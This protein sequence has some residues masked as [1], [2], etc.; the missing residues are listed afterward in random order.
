MRQGSHRK[1][2]GTMT[3]R[4]R[5][6]CGWRP[7]ERGFTL[8]E[9]LIVILIVGILA[10]VAVPLYLGYTKDAKIAEGKA[11]A[12]SAMTA[13]QGC[14]QYKGAGGTC[15]RADLLGDDRG[16]GV[17]GGG[18]EP[19]QHRDV[20]DEHGRDPALLDDL[21]DDGHRHRRRRGLLEDHRPTP[22]GD[23]C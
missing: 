18:H 3:P 12:G 8:V 17:V 11:L 19:D 23:T 13:L 15:A 6:A 14:V 4:T 9:L 1:G 7:G 22:D 16:D 5:R 21:A 20:P 2:P 10:A